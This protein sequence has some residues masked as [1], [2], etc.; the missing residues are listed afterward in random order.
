[1]YKNKG[2]FLSKEKSAFFILLRRNIMGRKLILL[3]TMNLLM[4]IS[5]FAYATPSTHI[6]A[7]STDIQPFGKSHFGIDVYIPVEDVVGGTSPSPITDIGLT[8]GI[9]PFKKFNTEIGIDHKSGFGDLDNYPW[10]FNTKVGIPEGAFEKYFPGIALGIYDIGTE[11]NKT[12]YNISYVK[13]AKTFIYLGRFSIG[14]FRGNSD[15]LLDK[16]GKSD[17]E[18]IF[19]AW[20]RTMSEISDRLWICVEYMGTDSP[21]GCFNFGFSYKFTDN[22]SVIVGYNIYNNDDLANTIT[23]QV[24]IDF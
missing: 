20:E 21:Y 7:P 15:L 17:N 11:H 16:D 24:D 13:I 18:G 3:S 12:N 23:V 10:Y 2:V 5:H 6:W 1:L 14:Y 19:C 22:I 4:A 9:L 8:I